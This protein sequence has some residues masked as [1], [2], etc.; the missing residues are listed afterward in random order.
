MTAIVLAEACLAKFGGD[1]MQETL[2][3]RQGYLQQ[4][5]EF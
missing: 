5:R 1:S 2:R 4:L 3:N